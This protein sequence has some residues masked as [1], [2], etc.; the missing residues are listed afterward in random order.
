MDNYA[1]MVS[2]SK[3]YL[4]GLK[5]L[6]SSIKKYG[7]NTAI[8]LY[9]TPDIDE[10]VFKEDSE[11]ALDASNREIVW[12][13]SEGKDPKVEMIIDR[14][15]VFAERGREYDA[16][17]LL[18]ADMFLTANV[19]LFFDLAKSGF[20]V[21]GSNGMIIDFDKTYQEKAGITLGVDNY[22]YSKVHTTVPLFL[23]KKDLDWFMY[24]YDA[25]IPGGLD[26]FLLLNIIG[27]LLGK[28]QKMICMPPYVFTGIH[29]WQMKPETA[30][31]EKAGLLL[32][33]TEEQVYMVHGKWWE[34]GWVDDLWPT[35]LR[36]FDAEDMG[37][38]CK[39]RSKKAIDLLK[40]RFEHY[41]KGDLE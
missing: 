27:I 5:A 40:D 4:P 14:F 21:A 38:K 29:H 37:K 25:W 20:I 35:M 17:C 19:D 6:L 24:V 22:P 9:V 32:S 15:K 30:V 10:E 16:V 1:F 18:D 34:K 39:K 11:L 13:V 2:A 26:D 12:S 7:G 33:G 8:E 36:Y 3:H 23:G 31:F 28:N 41:L